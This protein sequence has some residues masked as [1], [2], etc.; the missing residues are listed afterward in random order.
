[1][2]ERGSS[3]TNR[4]SCGNQPAHIRLINRRHAVRSATHTL[5][6]DPTTLFDADLTGQYISVRDFHIMCVAVLP[7]KTCAPL[8]VDPDAPL[9]FVVSRQLFQSVPRRN[10]QIIDYLR[11][12]D[13]LELAPGHVLHMR[14]K[15]FYPVAIEYRRSKLVGE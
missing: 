5:Y 13:R 9:P 15:G 4:L 7:Q 14:A 1:M 12:V 10:A 3:P 8:V 11:C 2:L 6:D